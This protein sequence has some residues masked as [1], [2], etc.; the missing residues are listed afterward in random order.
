MLLVI[1]GSVPWLG[2][3]LSWN[4]R[5]DVITLADALSW[6]TSRLD[7][8]M[9]KSNLNGVAI[10]SA[11]W[12]E[13]HDPTVVQGDSWLGQEVHVTAGHALVQI[14]VTDWTEAQREDPT[15]SAVL[16]WLKAQ[17]KTDLKALLT[18]HTSSGES[19]LILWN[20][21]NFTIHQG[22][23]YLHSMSK[24]E[25]KDLLL[26]VVPKAHCFDTLNG[27]H[28]DAG[29]QGVTIP[30]PCYGNTSG[31]QEWLIRCNNPSSPMCIA[32][33][34]RV[35]YQKHL[36]AWLWPLLLWTSWM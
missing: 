25:T 21:Q 5:R 22:V 18:E 27:C 12:A 3:I 17:K 35:I 2:S 30:C 4:I 9:V 33:N 14:H 19:Q 26:F 28:R 10:G 13:V 32:C 24:G 23:L 6:V 16:D 36:Y 1:N 31:G 20:W 34:I 29:H 15:L 8:D 7:M 11:H